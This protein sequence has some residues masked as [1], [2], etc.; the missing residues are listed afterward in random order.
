MIDEKKLEHLETIAKLPVRPGSDALA[1]VS[2]EIILE[3]IRLARLGLWAEK[4]MEVIEP[5]L[6]GEAGSDCNH[7]IVEATQALAALP[8]DKK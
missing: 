1:A 3:L 6:A 2:T 4:H 5:L 8:R 7:M